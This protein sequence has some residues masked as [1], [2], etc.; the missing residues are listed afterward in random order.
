M[1]QW[2][3]DLNNPYQWYQQ[4]INLGLLSIP[5]TVQ[6]EWVRNMRNPK[7]KNYPGFGCALLTAIRLRWLHRLQESVGVVIPF[8]LCHN[9][10]LGHVD[11]G[12]GVPWLLIW[13]MNSATNRAEYITS[14]E[15][16]VVC[17]FPRLRGQR[18]RRSLSSFSLVLQL[19]W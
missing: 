16:A 14:Y 11:G 3:Q 1:L 7:E 18:Q 9:D 8:L 19:A 6:R 12:D 10:C 4:S 13:W 17:T 2:I 15:L 5:Q